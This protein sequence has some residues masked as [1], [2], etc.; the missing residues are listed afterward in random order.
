MS[1]LKNLSICG[2]L[3][4]LASCAS[5]AAFPD[6][7]DE[8]GGIRKSEGLASDGA[9]RAAVPEDENVETKPAEESLSENKDKETVS[10]E[11]AAENEKDEENIVEKET[12]SAEESIG[13]MSEEEFLTRAEPLEAVKTKPV[14]TSEKMENIPSSETLAEMNN[15]AEKNKIENM[16]TGPDDNAPSITYRLETFYFNNGSSSLS[17]DELK[18]IRKIVKIAKANNGKIK[19]LG[20]ASSRTRDTDVVHH[21]LMNFRVSQA[22]ADA[23]AKALVRAGL[24]AS[25]VTV[26]AVSDSAPAYLEV[27]PEGERLNRRAEVYIS[28]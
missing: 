22:R 19:V 16:L 10:V 27:M 7:S 12:S 18:R 20:H 9:R 2:F 25:S 13:L 1:V 21:K 6:I 8:V 17:G 4:L 14:K 11:K 3:L 5:P 23:V 15:E 26:E 28:Y 24:P